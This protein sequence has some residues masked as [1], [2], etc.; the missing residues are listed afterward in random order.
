MKIRL[1]R[2]S[3]GRYFDAPTGFSF[4][5]LFFGFWT[6]LLRGDFFWAFWFFVLQVG[7]FK[8][9]GYY[10]LLSNIVLA[11]FFNKLFIKRRLKLGY[12]PVTKDDEF[13]LINYI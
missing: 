5:T 13:N 7:L 2:E 9:T 1:Y 12:K 6:P 4:T 3:T 8:G 10:A 11:A